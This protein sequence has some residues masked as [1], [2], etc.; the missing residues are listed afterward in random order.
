MTENPGVFAHR[1]RD[2]PAYRAGGLT[3]QGEQAMGRAGGE[4]FH[5]V[6]NAGKRPGQ[7]A[8]QGVEADSR[9]GQA[10]RVCVQH[11]L[12]SPP[13]AFLIHQAFEMVQMAE[14]APLEQGI[15]PHRDQGGRQG[16]REKLAK[17]LPVQAFRQVEQ[18]KI[19]FGQGLEQPSFLESPSGFRV[20]DEGE[21]GVEE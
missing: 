10:L 19:G 2:L 18:G 4:Q 16:Q 14:I 9:G 5:R 13:G 15:P 11:R 8:V 12:G 3:E 7:V 6:L 21:V 1:H 17:P 20:T